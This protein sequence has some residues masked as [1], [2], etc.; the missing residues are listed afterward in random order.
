MSATIGILVIGQSPRPALLREF[1]RIVPESVQ[2]VLR[3]AL[4]GMT[5]EE[6]A[7]HAPYSAQDTLFTILPDGTDIKISHATV[8]KRARIKLE[9]MQRAGCRLTLFCC[10]G[11]FDGLGDL[12]VLLPSRIHTHVTQAV[13][14]DRRLGVFVPLPEQ[15]GVALA[16]W[17]EC[18]FTDVVTQA[19]APNGS[20][21]QIELAA[22]QMAQATPD[23]VVYDCMGYGHELR[24]R[25]D[26]IITVPSILS[27][28]LVARVMAE[29]IDATA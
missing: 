22:C 14:K 1:R 8:G 23:L 28:S 10:T 25:A 27:I 12:A 9:E 3:G 7:Y 4:D 29:L 15:E 17:R 21:T 20:D 16:R 26:A 18:G 24:A 13:A 11:E 5:R 19:I 6:L 2:I